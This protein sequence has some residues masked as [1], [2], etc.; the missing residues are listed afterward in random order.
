MADDGYMTPEDTRT[1][2][3]TAALGFFIGF[4]ACWSMVLY[5]IVF[6]ISLQVRKGIPSRYIGTFV[7]QCIFWAVFGGALFPACAPGRPFREPEQHW[8]LSGCLASPAKY[9][10]LGVV[11]GVVYLLM[12]LVNYKNFKSLEKAQTVND[13]ERTIRSYQRCNPEISYSY[14]SYHT[15]TTTDKDGNTHTVT[16]TTY[17]GSVPFVFGQCEDETVDP[18][19]ELDSL[20]FATVRI[21][22]HIEYGD[23]E[24]LKKADQLMFQTDEE[25]RN[26]DRKYD[27]HWNYGLSNLPVE[28]NV[29]NDR[30][31]LNRTNCIIA[32]LCGFGWYFF[33]S[34][35]LNLSYKNFVI[36]KAVYSGSG[37]AIQSVQPESSAPVGPANSIFSFAQSSMNNKGGMNN[38][39]VSNQAQ[40]MTRRGDQGSIEMTN[41]IREI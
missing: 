7:I 33:A 37:S 1:E 22:H 38:L 2:P 13:L 17:R 41:P 23:S 30:S 29:F 19:D 3:T 34:L 21:T 31:S 10:G 35:G 6:M 20:G 25:Y 27:T 24:T 26:C 36:E 9:I 39:G 40:V 15:T 4:A 14:H 18:T 5:S 8:R 16:H 28:M 11:S 12:Q 32:S